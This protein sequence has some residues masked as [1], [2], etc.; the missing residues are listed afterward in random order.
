MPASSQKTTPTPLDKKLSL[1][2]ETLL[3]LGNATAGIE[4]LLL[5][6]V[7]RVACTANVSVD[8][9]ALLGAA[10][11]ERAATGTG[12]LGLD[13]LWMDVSL[14]GILLG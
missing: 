2:A 3:E 9:A 5:A 12:D 14:H 10:C 11:Y 13:I 8:A 4:D 6:G 1:L 7:E